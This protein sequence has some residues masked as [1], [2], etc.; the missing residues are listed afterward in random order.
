M[1]A[2][3]T[4]K[5]TLNEV[6]EKWKNLHSSAKKEFAGFTKEHKKTGGVCLIYLSEGIVPTLWDAIFDIKTKKLRNFLGFNTSVFIIY[7]SNG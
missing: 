3:G 6:K 4:E 7:V 1:N 2:V 5:R